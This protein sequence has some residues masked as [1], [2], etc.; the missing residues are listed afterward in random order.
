MWFGHEILHYAWRML[1]LVGLWALLCVGAFVGMGIL[2][3]GSCWMS[4]QY[5]KMFPQKAP[6]YVAGIQSGKDTWRRKEDAGIVYMGGHV[7]AER[8]GD[9]L[10]TVGKVV[11][12][13]FRML[14]LALVGILMVLWTIACAFGRGTRNTGRF[15]VAGHHTVKYRTCPKI[16]I[17]EDEAA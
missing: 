8:W 16:L 12:W 11:I 14:G 2:V 1:E 7:M 10:T 4:V 17:T 15:M 9:S 13:P 6:N 5:D 3:V